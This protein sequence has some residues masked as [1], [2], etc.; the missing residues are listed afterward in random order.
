MLIDLAALPPDLGD[1]IAAEIAAHQHAETEAKRWAK[2]LDHGT[3]AQIVEAA[4]LVTW[5]EEKLHAVTLA[6]SYRYVSRCQEVV[7][8]PW[9]PNH[10]RRPV[11]MRGS[12]TNLYRRF[13]FSPSNA[14][15]SGWCYH[16]I[17]RAL[18]MQRLTCFD[19]REFLDIADVYWDRLRAKHPG[20]RGYSRNK[21]CDLAPRASDCEAWVGGRRQCYSE[22]AY[23]H[24]L[25][26]HR[27]IRQT[28]KLDERAAALRW[29]SESSGLEEFP[30]KLAV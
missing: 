18:R 13:S 4:D 27:I 24:L 6:Q 14:N 28:H 22:H 7:R 5:S 2:L 20:I 11:L 23:E 10:P 9:P 16:V 25:K 30:S 1:K 29:S 3:D 19:L 21:I 8:A 26:L 12:R 15:P 17:S